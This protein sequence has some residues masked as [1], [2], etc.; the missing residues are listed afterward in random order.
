MNGD[1]V[2]RHFRERGLPGIGRRRRFWQV[3]TAGK[4]ETLDAGQVR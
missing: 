1:V 2:C 4:D 3:R